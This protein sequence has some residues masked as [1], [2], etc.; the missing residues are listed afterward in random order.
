MAK[1]ASRP[2]RRPEPTAVCAT[3]TKLG[4]GLAAAIRWTAARPSRGRMYE[5]IAL[6]DRALPA[7]SSG[8]FSCA[9]GA[10]DERGPQDALLVA[11]SDRFAA[12]GGGDDAGA[13]NIDQAQSLHQA[14]EGVDLVGRAG[15]LE[16]ER[17]ALG[18]NHLGAKHVGK[19]QRLD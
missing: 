3:R 13:A 17:I 19:P 5:L 2:A 1:A 15:D 8:A 9:L 14:D 7:R 4:P 6:L 11:A 10:Q 12:A 18:I 16:H